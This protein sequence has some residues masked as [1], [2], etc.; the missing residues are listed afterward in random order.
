VLARAAPRGSY[1]AAYGN[2]PSLC[3][4]F[5]GRSARL[6]RRIKASPSRLTTNTEP[7]RRSS[8]GWRGAVNLSVAANRL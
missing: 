4:G 6:L 7:I 5:G 2:I 3:K 1:S 8:R